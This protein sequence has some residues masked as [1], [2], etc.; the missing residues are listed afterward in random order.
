LSIKQRLLQENITLDDEVFEHIEQYKKLLLKWNK[1]HNLTGIK[2]K[3]QLD[4]FIYD[5]IYPVNFLPKIKNLMDIGTG[6]GFPGMM[7]AMGMRDVEVTLVEPL[8]KRAS[9]LQFV[10]ATLAL[11]NVSV[12]N[13]RVEELESEPFDI[14]TSRAVTDTKLLL[15]LSKPFCHSKTQLLFYKGE[16]VYDEV[17]ES[18]EYEIIKAKKRH[19]LLIKGCQ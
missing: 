9:F 17:D 3:E 2:S 12:K 10:K 7:L 14:I 1:V 6:A 13:C 4:D 19:Y 16:H 15:E 8:A 5:S 11:E 18:L